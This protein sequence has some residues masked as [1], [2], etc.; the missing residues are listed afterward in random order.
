M[1]ILEFFRD[2]FDGFWYFVYLFVCV[3]AFFYVLGILAD[4]KRAII[5]KKLKEKKTYDIESGREAAIAAMETKQVLSVGGDEE[6]ENGGDSLNDLAKGNA[7]LNEAKK[8]KEEEVPAVMVLNSDASA[9][10]PQNETQ[11][12]IQQPGTETQTVQP[13]TIQP[14]QPTIQPPQQE[15]QSKAE[16][17]LVINSN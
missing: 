8:D 12:V 9:N 17:P 10:T 4:N 7:Q 3:L 13:P 2:V 6:L 1:F 14:A 15:E 16:E 5:N 11:P